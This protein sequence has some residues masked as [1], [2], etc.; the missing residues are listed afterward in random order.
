M[1][2]IFI[3]LAALALG[4]CYVEPA[5]D[6]TAE[7]GWIDAPPAYYVSAP[8]VYYHG[9]YAY[10]VDGRWYYNYGGRWGIFRREPRPLYQY[11]V[12]SAPRVRGPV[13]SAPP[14]HGPVY[15]APPARR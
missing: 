11:R 7:V 1:R 15:R 8:R 13:Y 12:Y 4:G 5:Y 3:L 10:Y 2:S 6:V 9:G 14:A